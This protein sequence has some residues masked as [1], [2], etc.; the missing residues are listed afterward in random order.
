MYYELWVH[1]QMWKLGTCK[2]FSHFKLKNYD[3]Q[4]L[5]VE[6]ILLENLFQGQK[7]FRNSARY[8]W[9]AR[10]FTIRMAH[11]IHH[12]FSCSDATYR[13]CL[14]PL[15]Q[16]GKPFVYSLSLSVV[17]NGVIFLSFIILLPTA[18][19]KTYR[20]L[21]TSHRDCYVCKYDD[22]YGSSFL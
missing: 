16:G 6:S 3:K 20:V 2:F 13:T 18:L 7:S 19:L 11:F 1:S 8:S 5:A 4:N 22:V 21:L 10:F 14:R 15:K 9:Y 17:W 12:L